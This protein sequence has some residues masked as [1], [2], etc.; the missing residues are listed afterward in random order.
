L[1]HLLK[2]SWNKFLIDKKLHL[3]TLS[4]KIKCFFYIKDQLNK[5][6]V[7]FTYRNRSTY[8]Q[9]VGEFGEFFW[10]Y[11]LSSTVL[12]NPLLCFSFRA[13]L[14]FSDDG[15]TIWNSKSKLHK[16]RRS[17]G[18]SFFNKEWRGLMLAYFSSIS[19]NNDQILIPLSLDKNLMLSN[20]PVTFT[21]DYGYEEPK[22]EGR[23]VPLDYFD[24][25]I[26]EDELNEFEEN[27][28]EE[29]A[30]EDEVI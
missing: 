2:E 21:C 13:H 25:M 5:D 1:V 27:E 30:K 28:I 4:N 8:K 14:V 19:D 9:L 6:K 24:E 3:Y 26:E 10:H 11:G 23:I 15:S 20:T 12:L 16:A 18:K 22:S 7:F 29:N 17:K